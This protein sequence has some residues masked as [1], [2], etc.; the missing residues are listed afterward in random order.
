MAQLLIVILH[1]SAQLPALLDAWQKTGVPGVSIIDS[2]GGYRAKNWLELAGL[3]AVG[4]IFFPSE[5]RNKILLAVIDDDALLQKAIAAAERVVQDFDQPNRGIL[6]TVPVGYALGLT[7]PAQTAPA[8]TSRPQPTEPDGSAGRITRNTPV[9]AV[10]R[11]LN[12]QPIL[13]QADQSLLEVAE[14]M[15]QQPAV[16]IACVLNAH[17]RLVGLLPLQTLA[18]DL[19]VSIVPEDFLAEAHSLENALHYADLS[20]AHTAA[21]AMRPAV[22]V[23]ETDLVKDAF[24]KMHDHQLPGLPIVDEQNHVTGYLSLLDLLALY[25]QSRK[26]A[27]PESE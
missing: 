18:D 3:S 7:Y 6:F 13:V 8:E 27:Q 14:A 26:I 20:R 11:T 5:T 10:H 2:A 16:T 12:L 15:V 17:R 21:Q 9:S 22:W 24:R 19:F 4:D 25:N 23:C 1:K